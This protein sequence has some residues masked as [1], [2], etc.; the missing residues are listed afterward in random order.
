[1]MDCDND[2][3]NNINDD[4]EPIL[5]WNSNLLLYKYTTCQEMYI[6]NDNDIDYDNYSEI[7]PKLKADA[8][9]S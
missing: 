9:P 3:N 4:D 5:S 6:D 7:L 1:M 2:D 8:T